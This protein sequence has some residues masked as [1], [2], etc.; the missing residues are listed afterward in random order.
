MRLMAS[1][2]DRLFFVYILK[3]DLRGTLM[4][5]AK[6]IFTIILMILILGCDEKAFNPDIVKKPDFSLTPRPDG[7]AELVTL[8]LT[9]QL[10]APTNVYNKVVKELKIIR[11]TWSDS[12]E[13]VN[14]VFEPFW[15]ESFIRVRATPE[16]FDSMM[17]NKYHYWDSLNAYFPLDSVSLRSVPSIDVWSASMHFKGRLNSLRLIDSYAGL[18]LVRSIDTD[19]R[20]L[21]D[22][23]ML[24]PLRIEGK[25]KYFFRY[26]YGD[27][28]NGCI[29]SEIYYFTVGNDSAYYHGVFI[30][31]PGDSPRPSW[32]DTALQALSDYHTWNAWKPE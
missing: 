28:Y 10:L 6:K 30:P 1:N 11:E 29:Y 24:L 8:Q 31:Y 22:Y 17:A 27:C 9:G 19:Y 2:I 14:I 23:P 3:I 13:H 4:K 5:T 21:G 20:W 7:E 18:P 26:A 32:A 25:N 16:T 12:I 15:R